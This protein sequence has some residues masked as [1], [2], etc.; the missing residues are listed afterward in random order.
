VTVR[1]VSG[2]DLAESEGEGLSG[3]QGGAAV[4]SGF[5]TVVADLGAG[6]GGQCPGIRGRAR[7]G[8]WCRWH[9]GR[10]QRH[11]GGSRRG[12]GGLPR[13]PPGLG[14][15]GGAK[16]I[17]ED[18][19][20]ALAGTASSRRHP[21][22]RAL[23]ATPSRAGRRTR[24]GDATSAGRV[25]AGRPAPMTSDERAMLQA[26]PHRHT[27]R[28]AFEPG[29]LPGDLLARG[30]TTAGSD[31]AAR[32]TPV[33]GPGHSRRALRERGRGVPGAPGGPVAACNWRPP[34]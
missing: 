4:V 24:S 19:F 3:G 16:G 13:L 27:H 18:A 12:H 7:L 2:R 34:G 15:T 26:A 25:R 14:R 23:A 21:V 6:G 17:R 9:R 8:A 32:R 30:K 28:G 29:P 33:S 10:R 22:A 5:E 20:A 11:R 1:R 31:L